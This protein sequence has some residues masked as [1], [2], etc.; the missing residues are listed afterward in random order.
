M[1]L[2]NYASDSDPDSE[3]EPLQPAAKSRPPVAP[4]PQAPVSI[5]SKK[6][7]PVK[8]T[9][10][11][12]SSSLNAEQHSDEEVDGAKGREMKKPRVTSQLGGMAGG[13]K[14]GYVISPL[15]PNLVVDPPN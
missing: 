12:S 9:L 13:G 5:K 10:D 2:A 4:K 3:S 7:G 15:P 8:I 6:R 14:G 11:Q 1:L